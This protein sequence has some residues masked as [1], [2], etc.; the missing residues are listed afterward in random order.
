[1]KKSLLAFLVFLFSQ[2]ISLAQE[3][4]YQV[5]A[6]KGNILV[7]GKNITSKT[8]LNVS[9]TIEVADDSSYLALISKDNKEVI[10]VSK[11]GNFKMSELPKTTL[12]SAYEKFVVDELAEV[13][14]WKE[15]TK[16]RFQNMNK[17]GSIFHHHHESIITELP[18]ENVKIYGNKI[19]LKWHLRRGMSFI[20]AVDKY[21][22]LIVN[23]ND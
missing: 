13:F 2:F 5:L 10:E 15:A 18:T 12:T 14:A 19:N 17:T 3:N 21:K 4:T 1:M 7:N 6:T 16:N 23:L 20:D 22:L 9:Q 11:K 8:A